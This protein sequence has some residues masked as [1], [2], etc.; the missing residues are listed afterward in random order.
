MTDI[1]LKRQEILKNYYLDPVKDYL[2]EIV[3]MQVDFDNCLSNP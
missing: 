3:H 1:E 2:K